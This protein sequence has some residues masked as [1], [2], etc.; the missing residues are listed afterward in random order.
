MPFSNSV[1]HKDECTCGSIDIG[2][3]V[4]REPGCRLG[5]HVLKCLTCSC[6]L[7]DE[8]ARNHESQ[9]HTVVPH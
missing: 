5:L 6:S 1:T 2:V 7:C 4:M 3:G 8:D 9:G